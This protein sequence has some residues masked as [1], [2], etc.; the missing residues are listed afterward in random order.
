M[1]CSQNALS[2]FE[3]LF[4]N[5]IRYTISIMLLNELATEYVSLI[6]PQAI[7]NCRIIRNISWPRD[8]MTFIK[9]KSKPTLLA[10]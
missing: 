5:I 6:A 2:Q 4:L 10:A 8:T 3:S 1:Y 7:T 9:S